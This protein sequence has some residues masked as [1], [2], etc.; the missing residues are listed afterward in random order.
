MDMKTYTT[1]PWI[2]GYPEHSPFDLNPP[3]YNLVPEVLD[4]G[5][6]DTEELLAAALAIAQKTDINCFCRMCGTNPLHTYG[7]QMHRKHLLWPDDMAITPPPPPDIILPAQFHVL[8]E[9]NPTGNSIVFLV[10]V[11]GAK[12]LLKI[13]TSSIPLTEFR[14]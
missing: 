10:E 13:V 5:Q 9:L 14:R 1:G 8:E 12:R 4:S 7:P 6:H 3:L 11:D 2:G